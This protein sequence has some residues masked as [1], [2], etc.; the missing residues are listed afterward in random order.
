MRR[1]ILMIWLAVSLALFS[2]GCDR[3]GEIIPGGG[4]DSTPEAN[5][6]Q[7]ADPI[8]GPGGLRDGEGGGGG[9]GPAIPDTELART[10]VELTLI[11][12]AGGSPVPV[13]SGSAV[14]VDAQARLL[15]TSYPLIDPTRPDGGLAY[16]TITVGVNRAAGA[17]PEE[18][19]QA[20]LAA[21]DA[22]HGLAVLRVTARADGSALG[23]NDFDLPAAVLGDSVGVRS[24]DQVRLFGHAGR[25]GGGT[26]PAEPVTV[27]TASVTGFRGDPDTTGRAWVKLDARLPAGTAGGPA[28]NAAGALVGV[29]AQLSYSATAP[30]G[31]LRP[32]ELA[33]PLIEATRAN[34]DAVAVS[35]V[36]RPGEGVPG[37]PNDGVAVS[38]PAFAADATS[39]GG[40][41]ELFDYMRTFAASVPAVYY[42]FA[43]QGAADGTVVQELWYLDGVLQDALSSSYSWTFGP[44]AVISDRL[45]AP[46]VS[47]IP[48]GTWTIEVWVGGTL[49]SAA[50]AF[51]GREPGAAAVGPL[52]FG[53]FASPDGTPS[54][55]PSS[56]SAQLLA[57]FDYAGA[58]GVRTHH[59][60]VSRDGQTVYQADALPWRGGDDGTWWVGYRPPEML[61]PGLWRVD[62][63]LDDVIAGSGEIQ[64]N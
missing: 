8:L 63:Y 45:E 19:F 23:E 9:S 62:I 22:R 47:G 6:T 41:I 5:G 32:L 57:F 53:A 10:V 54:G 31:Q 43:V 49:R 12:H 50:S 37:A 14:I 28:F 39:S 11:D 40:S 55:A 35:P 16:T 34:P 64:I 4:P 58:A 15:L 36:E 26:G 59:W 44:F 1:T 33:Q 7:S 61:E 2:A 17:A 27:A 46:N 51:V 13:R 18:A 52:R 29:L 24:G 25:G 38:R 20:R 30:V 21:V 3:A 42:E 48:S 56:G 60:V